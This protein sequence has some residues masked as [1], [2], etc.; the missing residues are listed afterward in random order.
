MDASAAGR[1]KVGVAARASAAAR[2]VKNTITAT[3]RRS[4]AAHSGM[5]L[6]FMTGGGWGVGSGTGRWRTLTT[7]GVQTGGVGVGST[8]WGAGA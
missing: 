5:P 6:G 8:R 2:R 3:R 1:R 4:T 7:G